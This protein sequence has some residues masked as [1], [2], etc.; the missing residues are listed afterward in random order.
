MNEI[1]VERKLDDLRA[2]YGELPVTEETFELSP[3]DYTEV[4]TATN[5]TGYDGNSVVFVVRDGGELPELSENIPAHA[6]GDTRD[7]V[8]MVLGRGAD[9]WA[10]PGGGEKMQYESMQGT[11][12]RRAN[13]QTNVR[14]TIDGVEEVFHR[15]YY[16]ETDAQGS[17]HTLDVYFRA[18]YASGSIEIDE[19]E[20]VGA[21]WFAEPPERM[22]EG[23]RQLWERFLDE[24]GRSE[25]L[26]DEAERTDEDAEAA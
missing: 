8:L 25:E 15:K 21:A 19:S 23:A 20:L 26:P 9:V 13:E 12:L 3:A 2:M 5:N 24:R 7:R 14:C 4:F 18:T 6:G 16:P 11:T 22:T 17:V 1:N 10:L